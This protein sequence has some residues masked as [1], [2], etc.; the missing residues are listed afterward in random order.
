MF[1]L[2][3]VGV[4]IGLERQV[5]AT[6]ALNEELLEAAEN[7]ASGWVQSLLSRRA[8]PNVQ[9]GFGNTPL[10]WAVIK[11]HKNVAEVLVRNENINLEVQDME[12]TSA[13]HLAAQI[14]RID[15]AEVLLDHDADLEYIDE[16]AWTA[17]HWAASEGHID[18]VK[19]LI[20]RGASLIAENGDGRSP[21]H[22][23]AENG[24]TAVVK[25]LIESGAELHAEDYT[26]AIPL[27]LSAENGHRDTTVCLIGMGSDL[28]S[29]D[30]R[31]FT[32]AD[33]AEIEGHL[34]IAELLRNPAKVALTRIDLSSNHGQQ[35]LEELDRLVISNQSIGHSYFEALAKTGQ[36]KRFPKPF[37]LEIAVRRYLAELARNPTLL[38]ETQE[39]QLF[40]LIHIIREVDQEL[41]ERKNNNLNE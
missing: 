4:A 15:I 31:G 24:H 12:G 30:A 18:F 17:L 41:L 16:C 6:P 29:R 32:P 27:H 28:N 37:V 36:L 26:R 21:L 40:N 3:T 1:F 22:L 7:G 33:F 38:N 9:D 2:F 23:A 39:S 5:L 25:L 11:N 35:A 10:H 34:S 20:E 8:N 19:M 14:N 13:L